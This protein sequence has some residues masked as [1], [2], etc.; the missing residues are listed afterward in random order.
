MTDF[1]NIVLPTNFSSCALNA[2]D[3]V[4]EMFKTDE[5]NLHLVYAC[6]PESCG[7]AKEHQEKEKEILGKLDDEKER[8]LGRSKGNI[9]VE[10]HAIEYAL[11]Y[12][13]QSFFE[14]LNTDI[15]FIGTDGL[16]PEMDD[17]Q[18]TNTEKFVSR[19]KE[20]I[21]IIPMG[22]KFKRFENTLLAS[23]YEYRN[24]GDKLDVFLKL[25]HKYH[26][27][28]FIVHVSKENKAMLGVSKLIEKARLK[29][30]LKAEKPE[31]HEISNENTEEGILK[32]IRSY[33][34]DIVGVIPKHQD[35]MQRLFHYSITK[36]I[37]E[38]TKIPALIIN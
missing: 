21:I 24:R 14:G 4:C 34:I 5:I 3:Y 18:Q 20:N 16:S 30:E 37:A 9:N 36:R 2:A 15:I 10:V 6:N 11:Y 38:K 27:H 22:A 17:S 25:M 19:V 23:D 7:S 29:E 12:I 13:P 28:N 1:K 33:D 32:F 26:T 31:F 8:I 35:I